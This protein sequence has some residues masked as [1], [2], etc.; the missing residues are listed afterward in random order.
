MGCIVIRRVTVSYPTEKLSDIGKIGE[1]VTCCELIHINL[2]GRIIYVIYLPISY[3]YIGML[4]HIW[5]FHMG[6]IEQNF[7]FRVGDP[8]Y[9]C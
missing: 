3:L 4:P 6:F 5:G 8:R 7:V 1:L 9:G 2:Y